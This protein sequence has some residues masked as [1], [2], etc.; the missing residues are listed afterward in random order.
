MALFDEVKALIDTLPGMG[1]CISGS[2]ALARAAPGL[3]IVPNDID[4]FCDQDAYQQICARKLFDKFGQCTRFLWEYSSIYTIYNYGLVQLIVHN[5]SGFRRYI[6]RGA[7]M[8]DFDIPVLS[9][10]YWAGRTEPI[11]PANFDSMVSTRR[12]SETCYVR[13]DRIL[14]YTKIFDFA[15][16]RL[17]YGT[18]VFTSSNI[19]EMLKLVGAN[20]NRYRWDVLMV[21]LNQ[22]QVDKICSVIGHD[23]VL[24]LRNCKD[25]CVYATTVILTNCVRC[26][27]L[28]EEPAT[29]VMIDCFDCTNQV[30]P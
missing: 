2:S 16:I 29:N 10:T 26:D 11:L 23:Y 27:I 8:F 3:G 17:T 5:Y 22:A 9:V 15:D 30:T 28:Q 18:L 21:S 12:I 4:V 7:C 20:T 19:D 24:M 1:V 6:E 14:K 13:A 25:I